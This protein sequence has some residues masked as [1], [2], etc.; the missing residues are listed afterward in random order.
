M[1]AASLRPYSDHLVIL[2]VGR[3]V[4]A[5]GSSGFGVGRVLCGGSHHSMHTIARRGRLSTH[6]MCGFNK[7]VDSASSAGDPPSVYRR[8]KRERCAAH[9]ARLTARRAD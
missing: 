9:T 3:D 4:G 6:C 1:R 7:M 5:L 8:V 2:H